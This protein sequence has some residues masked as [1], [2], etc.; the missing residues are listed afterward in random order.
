VIPVA[1]NMLASS[2]ESAWISRASGTPGNLPRW[3]RHL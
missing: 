1:T 2:R 3:S